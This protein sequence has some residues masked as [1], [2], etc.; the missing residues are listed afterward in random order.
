[1]NFAG[2]RPDLLSFISDA[3]PSKQNKFVPGCHVPVLPPDALIEAKPD[4]VVVFAWNIAE[5]IVESQQHVREWGGR[6]V[7]FIPELK[8]L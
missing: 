6:F 1:M 3:A 4:W 7:V 5:E 2:I 8:E